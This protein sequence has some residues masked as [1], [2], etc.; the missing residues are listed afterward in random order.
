MSDQAFCVFIVPVYGNKGRSHIITGLSLI[1]LIKYTKGAAMKKLCILALL[2]FSTIVLAQDPQQEINLI[3]Q[4]QSLTR[5]AT[6]EPGIT[7]VSYLS[8]KERAELCGF[9]P[10]PTVHEQ[11]PPRVESYQARGSADLRK[12][13][14]ITPIKNQGKCGSCWAFAM[15]ACVEAAHGGGLDLSEQQLVS[16]CTAC[17]GCQGGYISPTG[18]WIRDNGGLVTE[19]VYPYT[20]GT[21]GKNGTCNTPG[22]VKAYGISSVHDIDWWDPEQDVKEALD[23]G[24]AVDTGMYVYQDFFNYKGGIYKHV[25]G[26]LAGGHAVVIVGYDD[27]QGC[28]IVKNSWGTGWGEN[29]YFRIA[30]GECEIPMNACYVKK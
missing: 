10:V 20:S 8:Y 16:C 26:D 19:N 22:G 5:S 25:T 4:I 17:M 12:L 13:G 15:T 30:Y 24:Y 28:W 11:E 3:Q 18:E 2:I 7:S 14:I 29:G 23:N 6:W 1:G 21:N 9:Y 27:A